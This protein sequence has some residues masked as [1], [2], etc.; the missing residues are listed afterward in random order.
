MIPTFQEFI[1]IAALAAAFLA[2][3][4]LIGRSSRRGNQI[5]DDVI[6]RRRLAKMISHRQPRTQ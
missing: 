1:V 6:A 3:F 4:G 2:I 5:L